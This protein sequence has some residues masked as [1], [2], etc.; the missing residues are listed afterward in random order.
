MKI[1]ISRRIIF[2]GLLWAGCKE[3]IQPTATDKSFKNRPL[4]LA[5]NVTY[6]YSELGRPIA[7]LQARCIKEFIS[8]RAEENYSRLEGNVEIRFFDSSGSVESHLQADTAEFFE[9]RGVAK[10]WGKVIVTNSKGER[11]ET[12]QLYWRKKDNTIHTHSFVK[13]Y[14]QEEVLIGDSLIASP[15]FQ[16]YRLYKIKGSLQIKEEK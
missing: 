5:Y 15:N 14:T 12:Q 10:A 3:P 7:Q 9:A 8:E 11:L 4:S 2:L 1:K 6:I 16:R 13:I